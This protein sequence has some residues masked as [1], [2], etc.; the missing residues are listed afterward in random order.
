ERAGATVHRGL[1]RT[2]VVGTLTRG[3]GPVIGLR[4]DMD[5]LD[6]QELGDASHRSTIPGKMHGCGHDGHTAMLLGAARH[7]A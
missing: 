6:M 1:G 2:G 3:G 4:A 5:A 7:L